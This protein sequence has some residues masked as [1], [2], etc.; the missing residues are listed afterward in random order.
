M[1]IIFKIISATPPINILLGNSRHN[2]ECGVINAK[3]LF[4]YFLKKIIL[5]KAVCE[6]VLNIE[7]IL[8]D[9]VNDL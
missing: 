7:V 5:I 1:F 8:H 2:V 3:K 4:F 9:C 6:N